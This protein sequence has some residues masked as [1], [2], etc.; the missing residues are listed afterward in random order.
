MIL[1]KTISEDGELIHYAIL[2]NVEPIYFKVA[3]KEQVCKYVM[4][5]E[6]KSIDKN[7]TLMLVK[8]LCGNKA[9]HAKWVH[10]LKQNTNVKDREHNQILIIFLYVDDLLVTCICNTEI[11][12]SKVYF[13][14]ITMRDNPLW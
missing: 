11:E 12:V 9:I 5:V 2:S 8:L 13:L 7:R 3:L 6:L 14:K 10:K 4:L 1:D